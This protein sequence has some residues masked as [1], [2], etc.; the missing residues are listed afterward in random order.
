MKNITDTKMAM[1]FAEL[2]AS[3]ARN[4]LCAQQAE[5]KGDLQTAK[6]LEAVA[7]SESIKARRTLVYLRGKMSDL[8]SY[9]QD[10]IEEKHRIASIDYPALATEFAE[11]GLKHETETFSRYAAVAKNHHQLLSEMLGTAEA[12]QLY[13]CTVCG[14]IASSVAPENCPVCNAVGKKFKSP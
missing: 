5:K 3:A 11:E 2:S 7:E 6:L 1:T 10:L 12:T 14:F 9:L 13:I 8:T 4:Q